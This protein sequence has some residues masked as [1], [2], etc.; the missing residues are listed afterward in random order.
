MYHITYMIHWSTKEHNELI[1]KTNRITGV[2]NKLM[3][4]KGKA[5]VRD[6]QADWD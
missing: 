3:V 6:K 5:G 1:Y 2:E 4:T